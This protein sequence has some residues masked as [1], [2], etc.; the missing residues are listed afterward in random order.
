[1]SKYKPRLVKH[2]VKVTRGDSKK[3]VYRAIRNIQQI[4]NKQA[5]GTTRINRQCLMVR[6]EGIY[7]VV[8]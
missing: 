7:W 3:I 5:V 6:Q 8:V 1:M 4:K 2:P